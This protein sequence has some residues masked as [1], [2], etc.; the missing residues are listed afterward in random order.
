MAQHRAH[1]TPPATPGGNAPAAPA[2][3]TPETVERLLPPELAAMMPEA[4]LAA[5]PKRLGHYVDL[6]CTWNGA[7]NLTGG[8]NR[9]DILKHLV[10][11]SFHLAIFLHSPALERA[12]GDAR[13]NGP[14]I[15]DLGAGGGLPGIPLRMVWE[16]GEYTLVEVREKRALFL[17]NALAILGLVRTSVFRGPAEQLFAEQPHGADWILSRAFMPWQKLLAFCRPALRPRGVAIVFAT[18]ACGDLPAPWRLLAEAA[19]TV[20]TSQRWLWALQLTPK[21]A[22][23]PR[24]D[25]HE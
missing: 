21:V 6:L 12:A 14:R 23:A 13:S 22:D 15:W 19:Y 10:P 17:A 18:K 3:L 7:V 1:Q 5:L 8:R 2:A 4:L 11:D 24:E 25:C 16:R 9:T 20:G